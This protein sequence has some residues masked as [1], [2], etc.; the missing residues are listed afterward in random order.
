MEAGAF[1]LAL[2]KY[3][4]APEYF[5]AR[6]SEGRDVFLDIATVLKQ[7]HDTYQAEDLATKNALLRLEGEL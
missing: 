2:A 7:A 3:K 6:L 1:G 4:P 5:S